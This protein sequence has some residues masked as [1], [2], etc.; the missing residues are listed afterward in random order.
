MI[1]PMRWL[2]PSG[3]A[4]VRVGMCKL[5]CIFRRLLHGTYSDVTRGSC[6]V[7][8]ISSVW[9]DGSRSE[10]ELGRP[11]KRSGF[12]LQKGRLQVVVADS[13]AWLGKVGK[14]SHRDSWLKSLRTLDSHKCFFTAKL[15]PL[16]AINGEHT[17]NYSW[18][19]SNP[20]ASE[21][22]GSGLGLLLQRI[23]LS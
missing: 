6:S 8:R 17:L 2:F 12:W 15:L 14:S 22:L 4:L 21:P 16:S 7:L 9:W 20:L 18:S 5:Q 13:M 3:V 10:A 19:G 23:K 1:L 11:Q